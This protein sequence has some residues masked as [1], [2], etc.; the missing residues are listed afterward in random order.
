MPKILNLLIKIYLGDG[1]LDFL[2]LY[3]NDELGFS[4]TEHFA[5]GTKN[6]TPY[7]FICNLNPAS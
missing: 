5:L 4:W 7:C 6:Y 2:E 3:Q 1:H